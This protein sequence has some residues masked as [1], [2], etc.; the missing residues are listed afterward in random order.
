MFMDQKVYASDYLHFSIIHH[1]L[2]T[3]RILFIGTYVT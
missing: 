3:L 1:F 2:D